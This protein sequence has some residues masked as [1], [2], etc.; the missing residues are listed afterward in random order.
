MDSATVGCELEQLLLG[1]WSDPVEE[2]T[3]LRRVVGLTWGKREGYC[4]LGIRGNHMNLGGPS[5]E[6]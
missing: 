4:C 1:G 2:F 5:T 6:R 3:S